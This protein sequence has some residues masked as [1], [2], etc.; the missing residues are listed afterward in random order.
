M[1]D[2]TAFGVSQEFH[3]TDLERSVFFIGENL[4]AGYSSDE[5]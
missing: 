4:T 3:P 2:W 1:T 5:M